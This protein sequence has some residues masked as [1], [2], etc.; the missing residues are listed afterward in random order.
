MTQISAFIVL[1]LLSHNIKYRRFT[2]IPFSLLFVLVY[3][4]LL[5]G[6][7]YLDTLLEAAMTVTYWVTMIFALLC[8][9]IFL[10]DLNSLCISS[11]ITIF[12]ISLIV[13]LLVGLADILILPNSWPFN[14][15]IAFL[16]IGILIKFIVIKKLKASIF[17]LLLLWVFFIFRQFVVLFHV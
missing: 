9:L 13:T 3:A 14:N 5:F 8:S 4:S 16:T 10:I 7:I 2:P 1:V 12:V 11:N 15:L 6:T 17:P